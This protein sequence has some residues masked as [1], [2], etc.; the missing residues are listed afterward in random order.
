MAMVLN[1]KGATSKN[2]LTATHQWDNTHKREHSCQAM[3]ASQS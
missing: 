1:V 2:V 3:H